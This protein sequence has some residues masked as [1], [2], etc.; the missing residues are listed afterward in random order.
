MINSVKKMLREKWTDNKLE[1]TADNR[2]IVTVRGEVSDW[3]T[4]VAIGHAIAKIDDV[5]N[6]VNELS[7]KGLHIP[8]KDY[9]KIV[10]D[11]KAIGEVDDVDV[12]I[13]GAGVSGCGVART[14]SKYDLNILVVE[15]SDDV[16]TGASKAN[17]GNIHAG[18]AAQPGT[19]KAKL[20]IEGNKMYT[21]WAE[22]L[23]FELQRCG[24][25]GVVA[26]Q[27]DMVALQY[28]YKAAMANGVE[29]VELV[30]GK[31]ALE[32]E[33]KLA[34]AGVDIIAGMW[35]PS[36]GLV[37]PYE[38]V[39]ALAENA[40]NN[41]VIFRFNCSVGDVTWEKGQVTGVITNQGIIKAKYVINCAGVYADEMSQMAGDKSYTIHARKGTIAILDKNVK[42][43]YDSLCEIVSLKTLMLKN[44]DSKG[45]GMCR[46]P[47]W[48]IL[49]G[50]SATETPDKE[51][52]TTTPED[53][54]Y[55]MGRNQN[56]Q[57]SY[58]NIIRIFAGARPADYK[59][60]FVIEMSPITHGFINCGGIQSPGL[61]AAPAIAKMV[62]EILT[63]D[64]EEK[65]YPLK[66]KVDY[67]P[68]RK[69][70]TQF[71]N[72]THDEQDEL[73]TKNPAYG[74]IICR[75]E[76]I[77]EGEIL[78]AIRSPIIPSSIDAIKRRTRAGMGRC[79]G[80]F[81]QPR[82]LELLARELGKDW[83]EINLTGEQTNI[84]ISSTRQETIAEMEEKNETISY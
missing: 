66:Q 84:L 28:G 1:V 57:V 50:P 63:N 10:E 79:Q 53:L 51:D 81:C 58:G 15:M 2:N 19:L 73:I 33:P 32:L 55:S 56:D 70:K 41:G 27:E 37:E 52:T 62:T 12:V 20:N 75:C 59:E 8:R 78:D 7:V 13:I 23:G 31:R 36:M 48:N 3:N 17:N 6:V 42:P 4:V 26:T 35:L 22:E 46:T 5:K 21:K 25:L 69:R 47:E 54:A 39:V 34:N 43:E 24:A 68:I 76:T 74:R 60:D 29:G 71:R 30:D 77:T 61:A 38:V 16:A 40:A 9:T 67:D 44:A 72:M 14:L 80:G 83:I 18:H 49:L 11:G 45:G 82:V 64:Y 65:G